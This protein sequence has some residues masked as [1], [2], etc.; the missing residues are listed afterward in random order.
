MEKNGNTEKQ[1]GH[2]EPTDHQLEQ[3]VP[4]MNAIG[5]SSTLE[6]NLLD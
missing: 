3:F 5:N 2:S 4:D 6:G 1:N